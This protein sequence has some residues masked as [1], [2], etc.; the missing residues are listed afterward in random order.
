MSDNLVP[1]ASPESS[2][3]AVQGAD[4]ARIATRAELLPE[5]RAAGS[6]DPEHQAAEIL[7]DSEERTEH[8]EETGEASSQTST[9]DERPAP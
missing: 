3:D 9:P 2:D 1:S 8:P 4:E 6:D 5:E 7:R